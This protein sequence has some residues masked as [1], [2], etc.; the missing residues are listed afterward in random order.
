MS[1]GVGWMILESVYVWVNFVYCEIV[2]VGF[3]EFFCKYVVYTCEL[4]I[5]DLCVR[6]CV[7]VFII[8]RLD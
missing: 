3:G 1:F 8:F 5:R 4:G 7:Y 6:G 2:Y